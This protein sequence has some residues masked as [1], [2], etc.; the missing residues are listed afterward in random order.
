MDDQLKCFTNWKCV[1]R[2]PSEQ[3]LGNQQDRECVHENRE[4]ENT[5]AHSEEL[6]GIFKKG[7]SCVC[8]CV[9][10]ANWWPAEFYSKNVLKGFNTFTSVSFTHFQYFE[11][12]SFYLFQM[13]CSDWCH[14][15]GRKKLWDFATVKALSFSYISSIYV[16]WVT[17]SPCSGSVQA[18]SLQRFYFLI[19]LHI[20]PASCVP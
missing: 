12:I 1:C 2:I 3:H 18:S 4:P 15:L 10:R 14:Y 17:E 9:R 6:S 16:S 8:V 20:Q 7:V 5:P 19:W 11:L 13:P